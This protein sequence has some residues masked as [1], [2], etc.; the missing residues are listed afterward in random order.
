MPEQIYKLTPSRDLQ[1]YF[2]MPSAIAAISQSSETGFTVSGKWR[3]QFDWAVVEWNRD[4][5][6]EH[7]SLRYLP[8]GDLSG[9]TLSYTETRQRCIPFESNLVPVVDWNDL[10]VWAS[11]GGTETVYHVPFVPPPDA[12]NQNTGILI[13]PVGNYVPASATLTLVASP[14]TGLRAGVAVLDEHYY[15]IVADGDSLADIAAGI[16]T[17]INQ[18][19][20]NQAAPDFT[21]TSD[22]PSVIITW[23]PQSTNYW[24]LGANGNR[25]TVYGFAEESAQIWE[26]PS[27]PF[28]GG[29]F[30]ASY[31][32][33]IDFGNLKTP[34]GD[35]VP[36]NSIRKLRWTWAADLQAASFAQTEFEVQ[37][38]DWKVS[39]ENRIYSVAG[40]GSRRIEDNGPGVTY[41]GNWNT[42]FPG[43]YSGSTIHWTETQGDT[44]IIQY[45]EA[46]EHQLF[47]GTRLLAVGANV[48]VSLDGQ[49]LPQP[50]TSFLNGE[51]VLVRSP[52]GTFG[53]GSH[54]VSLQ[55]QGPVNGVLYFDFLE[56][57][58]PSTN[59]PDFDA[60]TL[61]LATDWDTYHSQSL[62]AERT[63]WLIQKLGFNGRV[64]HYTGALWFYEIYRPQT[65]YAALTV[66]FVEQEFSNSPIM[67]LDITPAPT[68]SV[69]NPQPAT[70]Q[71]QVLPDDDVNTVAQAFAALVNTGIN[72]AW[73]S[74][75]GAQLTLTARA[76]GPDGNGIGVQLNPASQGYGLEGGGI[77]G[78][79][80]YGAPYNLDPN[81]PLVLAADY[82]RTDLA[83]SPSINRAAR[84]WHL[85]YYQA[86]KSY[87]ISV[88]TSFSTELMNGDPD[89]AAGIV[90]QYPDGAPVVLNTPAIQT[91][92]SPFS[93]AY[94]TQNYLEMASLQ[95]TAGLQPYLQFGEVQWWY[96]PNAAGMP[97]YDA[98]TQQQ[99]EAQYGVAM[100]TIPSN[101]S[102]PSAYPNE[103]AFLPTVIGSYT[104]AIRN[105]VLSQF[106]TCCFEVLYPTDT[107][108]TNLNQIVNYPASDWTPANLNSLKTESFTFTGNHNLDQSTYSIGVSASKGFASSN[109]S[110]LVGIGSALT[111]WG[112]E[113]DIAQAQG[114]ESVVLFALDQ[115]CL[116]G[117]PPPPFVNSTR[118]LRQG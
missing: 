51:D 61:S 23:S 84:D 2:L 96:F 63:A 20:A 105:A 60:N 97:F 48:S 116:I 11:T 46:N 83:A 72:V 92:F 28:T 43:N 19:E 81:N 117:Y 98:Y 100:Q 1:C 4:N 79:G 17:N 62:P 47:L 30:P 24:H 90:Q 87:G 64:N 39:G 55:H 29:Q 101:T 99:F 69:P 9:L 70:L 13:T 41:I 110:H 32:V 107:N 3:Q 25:V 104:A 68:Q 10:R 57:V 42:D 109:R 33:T 38:S 37:I 88:V 115:Y 94:W 5:T 85:A 65:Q 50:T 118:T 74:A 26:Q 77:T 66:T 106:P 58:Y 7:P 14:K 44:C 15:Y 91:N 52:L 113:V 103:M 86:L 71:H 67:K 8:D 112:K 12:S 40:P 95:S 18:V 16:A 36:T 80:I 93:I 73:A 6:F 111:A 54:T 108:D 75:S 89:P 31:Q 34:T 27:A 21:A 45:E 82:W 56:I 22:G 114:L 49:T 78:G 59:L 102:D 76:M 35:V 53:A